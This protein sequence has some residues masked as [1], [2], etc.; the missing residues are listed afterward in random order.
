[1]SQ[2]MLQGRLVLTTRGR[3][4]HTK[5]DLNYAYYLKQK[6]FTAI[7]RLSHGI[8]FYGSLEL[9]AQVFNWDISLDT[10]NQVV[11]SNRP[12]I[13]AEIAD[14]TESVYIPIRPEYF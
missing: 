14:Y 2:T 1:M 4:P 8:C 12:T 13:P 5:I 3:D 7:T 9:F 6:G 10:K 11:C